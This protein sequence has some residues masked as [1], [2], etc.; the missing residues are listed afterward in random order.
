LSRTSAAR[1]Q[2]SNTRQ[3]LAKAELER[4]TI[5]TTEEVEDKRAARKR[6][7]EE[8]VVEL[9]E[10]RFKLRMQEEDLQLRRESQMMMSNMF[11]LMK[12][13]TEKKFLE[14]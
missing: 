2:D 3:I 4:V 12:S 5:I 1:E 11:S 7:D 14:D 6:K 8:H 10:R 9:E 13:L